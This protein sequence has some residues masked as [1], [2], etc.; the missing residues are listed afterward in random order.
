MRHQASEPHHL[1]HT[2]ACHLQTGN[3]EHGWRSGARSKRS[4]PVRWTPRR[5]APLLLA[6]TPTLRC[7]VCFLT[8]LPT[9]QAF[10]YAMN[11]TRS[12]GTCHH[13]NK[14][15][16]FGL[17]AF[18]L[19]M[20]QVQLTG[21]NRG[22]HLS[23]ADTAACAAA[24]GQWS[25]ALQT[26]LAE[27]KRSIYYPECACRMLAVF[28]VVSLLCPSGS[29]QTVW[30]IVHLDPWCCPCSPPPKGS[31]LY[32]RLIVLGRGAMAYGKFSVAKDCF[33]AAGAVLRLA[34]VQIQSHL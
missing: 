21:P 14:L 20:H 2:G 33:E 25:S 1:L 22:L 31:T 18:R 26:L 16:L 9:L 13:A 12:H 6:A 29:K 15:W 8:F 32:Q 7:G 28:H 11:C 23:A 4:T 34:R 19:I 27:Y 24:A 10:P 3:G 5:S 30:C 17:I